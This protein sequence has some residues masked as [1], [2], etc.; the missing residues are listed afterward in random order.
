V[1][2][3][4]TEIAT[5]QVEQMRALGSPPFVGALEGILKIAT[6]FDE[7]GYMKGV[8]DRARL[9]RQWMGFLERWP[10]VLAPVSVRPTHPFDFDLG[11]DAAVR[12][13]FWNDMRFNCAVS[14]LGLPVTA[15][16]V[17]FAGGAPMGV[18]LIT[19]RYREDVGLD[20]AAAIEARLGVLA[21][22]LWSRSAQLPLD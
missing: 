3:I 11:G 15:T 14:V 9:L 19:S 10:V 20:A 13:Y 6:I 22:Q 17:G 12:Q 7:A 16:P 21:H 8:A 5:V 18:Q 1:N 2:L 4:S